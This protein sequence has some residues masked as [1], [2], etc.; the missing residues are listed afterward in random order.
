MNGKQDPGARAGAT[1]VEKPSHANAAGLP[2]LADRHKK[3][4]KLEVAA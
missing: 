3:S 4:H 2:R 1:G